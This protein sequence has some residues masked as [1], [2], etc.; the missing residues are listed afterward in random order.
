[1]ERRLLVMWTVYDHPRDY[2]Q[3]FVAR[4]WEIHP[5]GER[6]TDEILKFASLEILR[7]VMQ[8]KGLSRLTRSPGDDPVIVETWL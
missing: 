6:M 7:E 1:M 5:G 8:R 3:H 4:K 2:P